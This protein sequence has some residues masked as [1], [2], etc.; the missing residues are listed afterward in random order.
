MALIYSSCSLQNQPTNNTRST[1]QTASHKLGD[2]S[3]FRTIVADTLALVDKNDLS[4]G[5]T[6]IKDLELAWDGAQ[7]GLKPRSPSDWHIVDGTIDTALKALRATPPDQIAC[8]E[9][10]QNVLKA[11]SDNGI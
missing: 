1:T 7:A 2:L 9:A 3:S 8:K 11:I 5:T 4:G 6:R 10:L